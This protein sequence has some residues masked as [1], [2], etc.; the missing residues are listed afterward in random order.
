MRARY[1]P[2]KMRCTSRL[3]VRA[4]GE[5]CTP[6]VT[7]NGLNKLIFHGFVI[8][9]Y[10]SLHFCLP[11]HCRKISLKLTFWHKKYI[12][13]YIVFV[14]AASYNVNIQEFCLRMPNANKNSF[15]SRWFIIGFNIMNNVQ[16]TTISCTL[17]CNYIFTA[18]INAYHVNFATLYSKKCI[19][20]I[21]EFP[22]NNEM[23]WW[24]YY[25]DLTFTNRHVLNKSL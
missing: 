20:R 12:P 5:I 9:R 13:N 17:Q 22:C 25:L 14:H 19:K 23:M 10:F 4:F 6:Y 3:F 7:S 11:V 1:T 18:W 16:D 15:L 2:F 24:I 8:Q 21:L